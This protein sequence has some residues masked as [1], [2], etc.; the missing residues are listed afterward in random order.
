M[1]TPDIEK[2]LRESI[3]LQ[4]RP[5]VGTIIALQPFQKARSLK[6]Y[7]QLAGN[8]ETSVERKY[9]GEYCQIHVW[10]AG[11]DSR[12]TIF[13]KS[14]RDSTKDRKGLHNPG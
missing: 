14:G 4:I 3:L 11:G 1:P 7:R 2:Q 13:S 12:I 8:K 10:M 5:R 9:D 6:H